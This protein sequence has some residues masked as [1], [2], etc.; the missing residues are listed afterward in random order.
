MTENTGE[1]EP[2][3]HDI[4]FDRLAAKTFF[5]QDSKLHPIY[6]PPSNV[7]PELRK[8]I[9][10][11]W[12]SPN[13]VAKCE[14]DHPIPSEDCRCG[15]YTFATAQEALTQ[16]G[17]HASSVLAVLAPA[18][19]SMTGSLG[20]RS[21]SARVVAVWVR[22]FARKYN[23]DLEKNYPEVKFIDTLGGLLKAYPAIDDGGMERVLELEPRYI[24]EFLLTDRLQ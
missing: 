9:L 3:F 22:P 17:P 7:S 20:F 15:I 11:T 14:K 23:P 18:G 2:T 13:A 21:P 5:L 10:E 6:S 16:Y 8:H 19:L 1:I 12:W 24:K 4:D